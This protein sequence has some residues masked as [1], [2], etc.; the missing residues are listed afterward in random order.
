MKSLHLLPIAILLLSMLPSVNGINGSAFFMK[1]DSTAKI[2]ANF[3]FPVLNNNTWNFRPEILSSLY[4]PTP[5]SNG[6]TIN[7]VP[8]SF[9]MNESNL[10]VTYTITA[11]NNTKGVYA[12]LLHF[13]GLSPLVVGLNE[14]EINP[15]IFGKFFTATYECPAMFESTPKMNIMGYSNLVSKMIT[16]NH[17][18]NNPNLINQFGQL[19]K[20]PFKQ[21][22]AGIKP[23]DIKCREGF[24]LVIKHED[25]SPACITSLTAIMLGERG[26]ST[27]IQIHNPS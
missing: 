22:E 9:N 17:S 25:G 5:A 19:P 20:S 10:D 4:D 7:A 21:V 23:L 11:K 3:T 12:L 15:E 1:Q 8:S 18:A 14:S 26:W 16:I 27:N 6:L 24:L 2:Y 13:C